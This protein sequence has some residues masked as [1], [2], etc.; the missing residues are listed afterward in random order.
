MNVETYTIKVKSH[1]KGKHSLGLFGY[2]KDSKV[3]P[4]LNYKILRQ[5]NIIEQNDCYGSVLGIY[6][7][8]TLLYPG[9]III[10]Q[11][12]NIFMTNVTIQ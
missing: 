6:P 11:Y 8:D 12:A 9:D 3:C 2:I 5:S 4:Y 7:L 1:I 10:V